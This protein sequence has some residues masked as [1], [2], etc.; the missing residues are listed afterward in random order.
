MSQSTPPGPYGE[1][2]TQEWRLAH[3]RAGDAIMGSLGHQE[4]ASI[5][6]AIAA[7]H[8]A[9]ANIRAK[10]THPLEPEMD[11]MS[12]WLGMAGDE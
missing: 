1:P 7:A 6:V 10:P 2:F 9:A 8:Y 4:A 11:L 3:T 12:K 5:A